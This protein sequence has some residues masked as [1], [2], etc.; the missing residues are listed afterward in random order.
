MY[1]TTEY[2]EFH[3]VLLSLLSILLVIQSEEIKNSVRLRVLCG[4]K[5]E[6]QTKN[7]NNYGKR[8]FEV[9]DGDTHQ[10]TE[11]E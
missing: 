6:T 1:L 2:T 7:T 9:Q 5:K 10:P 4:E 8:N 3:G 11:Q